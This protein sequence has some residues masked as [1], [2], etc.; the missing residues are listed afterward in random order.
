V[1]TKWVDEVKT[2]SSLILNSKWKFKILNKNKK[3]QLTCIFNGFNSQQM[4]GKNQGIN[5]RKWS[6]KLFESF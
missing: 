5:N 2:S 6:Q 1:I 3:N 4:N